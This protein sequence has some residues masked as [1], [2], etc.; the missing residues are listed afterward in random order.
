MQQT[1]TW[2]GHGSWRMTTPK[3]TTIYL[4]PWITGN[5]ACPIGLEDIGAADLVCVT[6][7]HS[8]HLGNA[9]EIVHKTGATLVTLPEVAA[10]CSLHGIPYDDRGGCVH[11]GGTILQKDVQI[12][13][14]YALHTSDIMGKE[15]LEDNRVMPGSGT[16]G[17]I[18][19]PEDGVSVYFAGDTGLFGDMELIGKL[20]HPKVAVLPIGGKYTMGVMEAAYAME[21]LGSQVLIPGH[22]NT[23]PSQMADAD[24]LGRQMAVRCPSA[25]LVVLEPGESYTL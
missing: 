8:D 6:H 10:Y 7:G 11:T 5:P 18:L 3:G 4:D 20:Y 19:T 2:L 15:Y 13:A 14:V 23:F 22:Y 24:E 1:I 9:I 25:Q 12:R 21:L 17:M 16:C